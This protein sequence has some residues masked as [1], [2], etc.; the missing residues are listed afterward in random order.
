MEESEKILKQSPWDKASILSKVF[1]KW[2]FPLFWKGYHKNLGYEDLYKC[3]KDDDTKILGHTLGRQWKKQLAAKKP[4]LLL[5]IIR[6]FGAQWAAI[7]FIGMFEEWFLRVVQPILLGIVVRYFTDNTSVDPLYAYLSAAGVVLC[8]MIFI[9]MHHP[10]IVC[11]AHIGMKIRIACLSLMYRKILKLNFS[12]LSKTTVG[13]IINLMSNDVNRFDEAGMF[14]G[15]MFVAP[16]QTIIII[17]IL[18]Q[19]LG[20]ASLVGIVILTFFVPFQAFMGKLFS[21]VRGKIATSTDERIRLMSEIIGGMK[22][23]KMYA[24]EKPFAEMVAKVRKYVFITTYLQR[25]HNHHAQC[26]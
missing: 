6:A 22:V 23:I 10:Y 17:V 20:I 9:I 21:I 13:Q 19:Y 12:S 4:S 16:I 24:W 18:W 1:F 14:L 26:V 25:K 11:C 7:I 15:F 8:S 5:A 3:P 2:V